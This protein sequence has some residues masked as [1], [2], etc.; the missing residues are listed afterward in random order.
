MKQNKKKIIRI[1]GVGQDTK[2]GHT[3]ITQGADYNIFMGSEETHEYLTE[4]CEKIEKRIE[5]QG[6]TLEDIS[7]EELQEIIKEVTKKGS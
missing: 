3:R 7:V 4:L 5:E 6:L 2:D 1:L